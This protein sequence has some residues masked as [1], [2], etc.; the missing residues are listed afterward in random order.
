[1]IL[2]GRNRYGRR[3]CAVWGIC[4]LAAAALGAAEQHY[5]FHRPFPEEL[6]PIPVRDV[7]QDHQGFIWFIQLRTLYRYDGTRILPI[8]T[9]KEGELTALASDPQGN[10]WLGTKDGGLQIWERGAAQLSPWVDPLDE[11]GLHGFVTALT[12]DARGFLWAATSTGTLA[13]IELSSRR[14]TPFEPADI[15]PQQ[16]AGLE[17]TTLAVTPAPYVW[18]G[19]SG[20]EIYRHGVEDDAFERLALDHSGA[21]I[22]A[23]AEGQGDRLW[24]GTRAG[25]LIRVD[26]HSLESEVVIAVAAQAAG[27]SVAINALR[28]DLQGHLWVG[29][30]AGLMVLP[31]GA[32]ELQPARTDLQTALA[33][34]A[35]AVRALYLDRSGVIWIAD[36]EGGLLT[37]STRASAFDHWLIDQGEGSSLVTSLVTTPDGS[38]WVGTYQGGLLRRLPSGEL[39]HYDAGAS[40]STG[41]EGFTAMSLHVDRKGRL[42]IGTLLRGL[43]VLD[44]ATGQFRHYPENLD[45]PRALNNN[46]VFS[47]VERPDGQLWI[48]TYDGGLSLMDP[49]TESFTALPHDTVD[50]TSISESHVRSVLEDSQGRLWVGTRSQGLSLRLPGSDAFLHFRHDPQNPASLADDA[51]MAISE[52]SSGRIWLGTYQ[53]LQQVTVDGAHATFRSFRGQDGPAGPKVYSVIEDGDGFLWLST[54]QGISR[55]DPA[56]ATFTNLARNHGLPPGGYGYNAF[57]RADDGVIY[58][59][60]NYGVTSFRPE[61]ISLQA[62]APD[63]VL[64]GVLKL[65]RPVDFAAAGDRPGE[66]V[67]SHRDSLVSFEFSLLDFIAPEQ[68][69]YEHLLEGYDETWIDLGNH[70]RANYSNLPP[71]RYT[72]RVRGANS[73]GIWSAG[74]A[75]LAIRVLPPPWAAWWAYV[76]YALAACGVVLAYAR[77]QTRKQKRE[78]EYTQRLEREVYLRTRELAEQNEK[79][80]YAN[81][82]LEVASVTDSLT[83]VRNRRFLLTTI[84]QDI[85]LADRAMANQ[86]NEARQDSAFVFLLFDLDGFKEINDAYGH[87]AG[88]LVLFQIRD[89]LNQACRSSDTLIRWGGDEFLIF[90]REATRAHVEALAERI[91]QSISDHLFDIGTSEPVQLTCSLGFACYPFVPSSPRLYSWEEVID[92]ADR[93][94]YLAKRHGPNMWAGI[95]G[96]EQTV[97]TPPEDLLVMIM[98]RPE[99]LSAEGSVRLVTSRPTPRRPEEVPSPTPE[100][101]RAS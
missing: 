47:I 101:Q 61:A 6:S 71:G 55:F 21:A 49:E 82:L 9:L 48:G 63:I 90:A 11:S 3:R 36:D 80:R 52:D 88:D 27:P 31:P 19:T 75:S 91:R 58:Y 93:A 79:L 30:D 20:G 34:G 13:R 15:Q 78:A 62:Y 95:F 4:T 73:E 43:S 83:G 98:E 38:L 44:L 32:T 8:H 100:R 10:V 5:R 7:L 77:Y 16:P 24:A 70:Q 46:T 26:E 87:S 12:A 66:V 65:D 33:P 94:L 35:S 51:V 17:V 85:A 69:R 59:G 54:S 81:E 89:L 53:G 84:D 96:T 18:L 64:T 45:D 37:T 60:S 67:F 72:L 76:L 99:L 14:A 29:T 57:A 74:D 1:M 22:T 68:N 56:S 86:P 25:E 39:R 42:W 40:S 97:E 23:L 2:R 28:E 50:P 41:D 92:I